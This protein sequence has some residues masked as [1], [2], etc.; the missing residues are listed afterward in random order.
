MPNNRTPDIYNKK[1]KEKQT[2]LRTAKTKCKIHEKIQIYTEKHQET[3][4]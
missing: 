2:S 1:L 3:Y 4:N